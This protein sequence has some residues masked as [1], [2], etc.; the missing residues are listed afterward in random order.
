MA[1]FPT[2]ESDIIVLAQSI[3]QGL[4]IQ[5]GSFAKPPYCPN[6]FSLTGLT[7]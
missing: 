3:I 2:R 6:R 5:A 4:D 1:T 7:D